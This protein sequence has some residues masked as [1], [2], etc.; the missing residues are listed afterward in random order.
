MRVS[1]I[2][3]FDA[4]TNAVLPFLSLV[5]ISAPFLIR[6]SIIAGL[7]LYILAYSI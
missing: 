3:E 7:E 4:C 5:L 2:E 6:V 1:I